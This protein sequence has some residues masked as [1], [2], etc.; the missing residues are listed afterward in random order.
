MILL[1]T[2]L[3]AKIQ[4]SKLQVVIAGG[5][6]GLVSRF[7][8]APLDVLKIRLQLQIHSLSD[9]FDLVRKKARYGTAATFT[10]ILRDEGVTVCT[11]SYLRDW[12]SVDMCCRPSGKAISALNSSTLPMALSNSPPT[13]SQ[14]VHYTLSIFPIAPKLSYPAPLQAQQQLH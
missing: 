8:I 5:I 3:T 9:P 12:K 11:T 10:R 14:H 2:N 6:A 13:A 1:A 4:G 7:C